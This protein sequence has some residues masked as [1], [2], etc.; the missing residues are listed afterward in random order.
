VLGG[1]HS[2]RGDLTEIDVVKKLE[3]FRRN[4]NALKDISF[5]TISGSGPNG[6]IVHYRVD[7]NSDRTIKPGETLLVDS[8]GQYEDGTT[9]ITRTVAVGEVPTDTKRANTLVLKG[10]IAITRARW[11]VGLAGRDLDGFARMALWQAGMDYDHGTGHGVGSYLGV[12]EGPQG[13]ARR[14]TQPLEVGMIRPNE[15]GHYKEGAY[16]IRIENL[17]V[18]TP[19][20]IPKGGDREMLGF[21]TLTFVPIDRHLILADLLTFDERAWVNTYHAE[22]FEKLEKLVTAPTRAWLQNACAPI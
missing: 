1:K 2:A 6:A 16:G 8:G 13:I 21:E 12:H 15:P 3:A 19:P 22:V 4:T 18:V 7:E 5:E 14:Y 10:M 20:T 17:L 9:D 11:P